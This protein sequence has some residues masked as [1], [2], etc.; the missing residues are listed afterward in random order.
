MEAIPDVVMTLREMGLKMASRPDSYRVGES[1]GGP[2][3]EARM[4]VFGPAPRYLPSGIV[5]VRSA[6][7]FQTWWDQAVNKFS[8]EKEPVSA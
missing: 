1:P 6:A 5:R 3:F 8:D 7:E 4:K 2:Y